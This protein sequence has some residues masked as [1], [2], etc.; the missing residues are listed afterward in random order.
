MKEKIVPRIAL[1]NGDTS[2]PERM[3]VKEAFNK[4]ET[5]LLIITKA[6]SVGLDLQ[7]PSKVIMYDLWWNIP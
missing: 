4:G 2:G 6:G 3:R 7:C 5:D 1:Y